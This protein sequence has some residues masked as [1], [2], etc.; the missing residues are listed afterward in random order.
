MASS[1]V[2]KGAESADTDDTIFENV[3]FKE[4]EQKPSK[5]PDHPFTAD[6]RKRKRN[7]DDVVMNKDDSPST[8]PPPSKKARTDTQQH[9]GYNPKHHH[10]RRPRP[11]NYYQKKLKHN[12]SYHLR[13]QD[14]ESHPLSKIARSNWLNS[15]GVQFDASLVDR[16]YYEF[17]SIQNEDA[18]HNRTILEYSHYLEELL[19]IH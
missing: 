6:S 7:D 1:T 5:Q 8:N 17:I 9:P 3:E 19:T 12:K 18:K 10:Q 4:P 16:L 11:S 13:L 15:E 14:V 2:T